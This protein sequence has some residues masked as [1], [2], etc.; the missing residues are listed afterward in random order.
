MKLFKSASVV[1][2]LLALAA[3]ATNMHY[4]SSVVDY[5][6]PKLDKPVVTAEQVPVLRLPLRVGIAFVPRGSGKTYWASADSTLTENE[7]MQLMEE[8]GS[9]FTRLDYV[10]DIEIIPSAYLKPQGSFANL[11]QIQTM[12]GIDVVALISYDQSQFT[13]EGML[14][15]TYWT[16]IGAY[17]VSGEKNETH[18]M[19]DTAVYDISSHKLLF[20]APGL[21]QVKGSS[22]PVNLSEERRQD[23]LKGFQL[24]SQDLIV[25]LD[26]ALQRFSDKVK[27]RPEEFRIE[28]RPGYSGGAGGGGS[29][30]LGLII[31]L[32]VGVCLRRREG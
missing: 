25:N 30:G 18:T 15:F 32:L 20:R 11:E 5:L 31:P 23:S 24:A 10:K 4:S 13:D 14:S 22:T 26:A 9:H 21:S 19:L 7:K 1:V 12:F 2:L 27:A 28:H 8:V 17:V 16:L 3:C 6:Y 29:L